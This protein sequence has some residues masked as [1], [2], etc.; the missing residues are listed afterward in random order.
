LVSDGDGDTSALLDKKRSTALAPGLAEKRDGA[1]E[2]Q[3]ETVGID[4][5]LLPSTLA[6]ARILRLCCPGK[7]MVSS[8]ELREERKWSV[9]E[10]GSKRRLQRERKV[11]ISRG[12]LGLRCSQ[13][14]NDWASWAVL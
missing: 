6:P 2:E 1:E 12:E 7:A 13:H 11:F 3:G 14:G 9:G 10:N 5:R 8:V 4:P